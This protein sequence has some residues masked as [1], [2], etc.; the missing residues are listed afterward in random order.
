MKVSKI[1]AVVGLTIASSSFSAYSA[2]SADCDNFGGIVGDMQKIRNH[3]AS[4][5]IVLNNISNV[6]TS[7]DS[8][9]RRFAQPL[10]DFTDFIW[11]KPIDNMTPE[12]AENV[13]REF[14][15]S[16]LMTAR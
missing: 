14:C 13:G 5:Q 9:T 10:L 8:G 1:V 2:T 6:T 7:R 3:G 4:K 16:R 11:A 15:R 12:R